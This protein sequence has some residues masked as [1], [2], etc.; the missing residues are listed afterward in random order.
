MMDKNFH[1]KRCFRNRTD[2]RDLAESF[3][4]GHTENF[5]ADSALASYS[6][7]VVNL[8]KGN[9]NGGYQ[10]FTGINFLLFGVSDR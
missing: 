2:P 4:M 3:V 7:K 6:T 9:I 1:D 8:Y 5:I 10:M